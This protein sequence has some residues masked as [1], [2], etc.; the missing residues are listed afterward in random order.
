MKSKSCIHGAKSLPLGWGRLPVLCAASICVLI[1]L[2]AGVVLGDIQDTTGPDASHPAIQYGRPARDPVAELNRKLLDGTAH[3]QFDDKQGYLRSVLEQLKVP[4]QSQIVVFSRTSVQ[5]FRINPQNPR[6]LFF[7]DS[8][9]VGWVRDGFV[10]LA[11][12]DPEQGVIFYTLGQKQVDK[13]IFTRSDTCLSCHVSYNS[14]GVPGM[15]VR[16]VFPG[17]D[18]TPVRELGD[19]ITDD[20]SPF[21]ERWGGWYVTGHSGSARHMGNTVVADPSKPEFTIA[22]QSLNLGSLK[23]RFETDAYLSPYSDIVALMV[24]EHQ[25]HM[26]NLLTRAGWDTRSSLYEEQMGDTEK[27]RASR[28]AATL[29]MLD[30]TARELVDYMLFIDE[31]PLPDKIKGTSGFA[32]EFSTRGPRDSRGRSLREFDLQRHLMR[33]PCSYMIYSEAFESLPQEAKEAI[34]ERLWRVL[35][36]QEKSEKYSRL[37]LADRRAVVEILRETKNE[38][39]VYFQSIRK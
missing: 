38:L 14:L 18:G 10:E 36:S 5:M 13:P 32:E 1:L 11:A 30:D 2:I 35:S 15:L 33:Y 6:T 4:I 19:Y 9:A 34:Y 3:L 25:M 26:T 21:E 24:F 28:H 20:R 16:S 22:D 37:S 17:P 8:V 7:N 27:S 31:P 39:P 12:E 29:R 23:G